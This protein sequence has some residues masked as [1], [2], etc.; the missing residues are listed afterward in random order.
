M[1]LYIKS[2]VSLRCKMM[3]E[4]ELSNLGLRYVSLELGMVDILEDITDK[5][6]ELLRENLIKSGLV[7][8]E[9]KKAILIERIKNTVIELIHYSDDLPKENLSDLISFKLN[10]NYSYLA[11]IFS[12]DQGITIQH[13]IILH[14]IEKVKEFI[15]Y[16]ELS[17]TEIAD[18]LHY[19]SIA[20]LSNQFK[21]VT[22][23]SPSF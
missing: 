4:R 12:E 19:S 20:H 6:R 14:K 22:G 8:I 16:D 15:L 23:L 17:L 3:V 21:K 18:R 9:D 10:H 2:M 7:L 1:K 13:F 11:N 5:Q